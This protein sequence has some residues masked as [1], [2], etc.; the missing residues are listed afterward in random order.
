MKTRLADSLSLE[1]VTELYRCLLNDTIALAQTLDEVEVAMMCP[2]ADAE[3]LSH[4]VGK[5]V[6]VV[7]QTGQ[8]LAAGL[9]SVFS[10]IL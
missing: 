5:T 7:P 3:D 1:A 6:H 8:G 9:D 2:A 4:A 10:H